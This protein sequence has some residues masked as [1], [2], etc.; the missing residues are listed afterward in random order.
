MLDEMQISMGQDGFAS[1]SSEML[2]ICRFAAFPYDSPGPV[3]ESVSCSFAI[4]ANNLHAGDSL[5]P[6]LWQL[7]ITTPHT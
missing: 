3:K 1:K 6:Q 2:Y 4:F 7:E 5:L